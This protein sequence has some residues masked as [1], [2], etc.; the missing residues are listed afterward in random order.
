MLEN[1]ANRPQDW[2]S[3]L[4][5]AGI[6]DIEALLNAPL[7]DPGSLLKSEIPAARERV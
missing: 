1:S 6:L 5:G 2:D 7:P 4:F 3:S